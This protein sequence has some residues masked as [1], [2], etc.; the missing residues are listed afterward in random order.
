M[1]SPS[2]VHTTTDDFKPIKDIKALWFTN[3]IKIIDN[4]YAHFK[5]QLNA[6]KLDNYFCQ[7]AY[8]TF[9]YIFLIF[10]L[11]KNL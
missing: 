2:E 4:Y 11:F 6:K 3:L 5:K 1:W 9:Y 10:K 7:V 8:S